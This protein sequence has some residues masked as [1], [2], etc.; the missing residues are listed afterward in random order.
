M[1][2]SNNNNQASAPKNPMTK[3]RASQIQAA[4]DKKGGGGDGFKERAQS[5][6]D[7]NAAKNPQKK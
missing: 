5:A 3:D 4:N 1:P 2:G 6:A 7:K